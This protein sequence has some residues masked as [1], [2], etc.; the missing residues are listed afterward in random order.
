[1]HFFALALLLTLPSLCSAAEQQTIDTIAPWTAEIAQQ[2]ADGETFFYNSDISLAKI[3][4]T[5]ELKRL[6]DQ[7]EKIRRNLIKG[8]EKNPLGLLEVEKTDKRLMKLT[9]T[10]LSHNLLANS[11]EIIGDDEIKSQLANPASYT[12]IIKH[13]QEGWRRL[14][15]RPGNKYY[16]LTKKEDERVNAAL[17]E[18]IAKKLDLLE[19]KVW[20]VK[21]RGMHCVIGQKSYPFIKRKLGLQVKNKISEQ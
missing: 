20:D 18:A 21:S 6:N 16:L 8:Y 17:L 12:Q 7:D 14:K 1:M 19:I 4:I 11:L 3:L 9:Y 10:W 13:L 2:A 5:M 15:P